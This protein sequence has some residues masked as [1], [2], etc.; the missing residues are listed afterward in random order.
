MIYIIF[1]LLM[2][3]IYLAFAC[4]ETEKDALRI[5]I[6]NWKQVAISREQKYNHAKARECKCIPKYH[7]NRMKRRYK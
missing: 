7:N 3:A 6:A 1:I 5:E 4:H 2:A